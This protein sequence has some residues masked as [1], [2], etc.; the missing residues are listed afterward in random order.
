MGALRVERDSD[1]LRVTMA[2]PESRNAF[3]AGMISELAEAFVDVG[4]VRAVVLA[5]EGASFCAGADI[6]WM[7][8]SA[9]LDFEG[10]VAERR[11]CDAC[12]TRSTAAPRR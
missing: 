2:R 9:D 12:S 10:N 8:A 5:G 1:I 6:E 3:D 11:G 4:T 7:R